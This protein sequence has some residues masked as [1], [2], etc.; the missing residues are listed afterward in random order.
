MIS[1]LRNPTTLAYKTLDPKS[2]YI[3]PD[4]KLNKDINKFV[5]MTQAKLDD[6]SKS[7]KDK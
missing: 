2:P 1:I 6:K 5:A 4:R 3:K 7:P